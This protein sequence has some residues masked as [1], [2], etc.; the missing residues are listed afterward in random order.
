L[1]SS[2]LAISVTAPCTVIVKGVLEDGMIKDD[3]SFVVHRVLLI[4]DI[5]KH[6]ENARKQLSHHI[7]GLPH[8]WQVTYMSVNILMKKAWDMAER[9]GLE[10]E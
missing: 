7:A 1:K 4:E 3:A 10:F 9:K 6:R 8:A 2:A 5:I